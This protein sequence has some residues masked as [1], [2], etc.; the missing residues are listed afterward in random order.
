MKVKRLKIKRLPGI[1]QPFE[2]KM[3]GAGI[4]IIFGPNG[5]GKSSICR[6]VK[7]LY[8][9]N[10][11]PSQRISVKGDFELDGEHWLGRREGTSL[12]WR[13]EG[14]VSAA[15]NLP[16]FH[17]QQCFFL[18]LLDLI[19]PSLDSTTDIATEIKRQMWGGFDLDQTASK[20]FSDVT[21]YSCR[22]ERTN[23][24]RASMNVEEAKIQ[25]LHLQH[26][27]DKLES[28]E[29]K[30]K[31]A[32][33]SARRLISVERALGLADRQE[34]QAELMR[35]IKAL[36]NSL[37]RLI[38]SEVE[39]VQK[40]QSSVDKLTERIRSLRKNLD[41][42]RIQIQNS[43]LSAPLDAAEFATW[44]NKTDDLSQ[45][46]EKLNAAKT[47]RSARQ[48]ELS[49]ALS[50]IGE[51]KPDEIELDLTDHEQLF[52]FLRL[53]GKH[54]NKVSSIK[55]RLR[56]LERVDEQQDHEIDFDQYSEA[57][58][59]LRSWLREPNPDTLTDKN[60]TRRYWLVS[61]FILAVL[62]LLLAILVDP[63]FSL[64]AAVGIGIYLPVAF[65]GRIKP[66]SN[67]RET[68]ESAFKNM[69]VPEPDSW[70]TPS[71]ELRLHSLENE[72]ANHQAALQ[73]ARDRDVE[74]QTL[75]NKL[76]G[77][78]QEETDLEK[79]RQ[80][81][82]N[83]LG[84][85]V[86]LL[87]AEL[88]DAARALNQYRKAR[89]NF[90]LSVG[91]VGHLEIQYSDLLK[92]LANILTQYGE[93]PP[94]DAATARAHL[95]QLEFQIK[96]I[97]GALNKEQQ[98]TD[99]VE[100]YLSERNKE[101]SSIKNIY[102]KLAVEESDLQALQTLVNL[103]PDYQKLKNDAVLLEGKIELDRSE[104]N[105]VGESELA[106][107][108]ISSLELLKK[109][110][111]QA[112]DEE[113]ELRNEITEIKVQVDEAKHSQ[114]VQNLI[115]QREQ[116]RTKLHDLREKALFAKAGQFL[117]DDVR[118]RYEQTQMP[119]VYDRAR[120]HFSLFTKHS[121]ELHLSK[122]VN[123]HRLFATDLRRGSSLGRELS[124][125]SDGT[126]SQLLLAARIAFAEEVENG[127]ILPLFLDEALDQSDPVRFEAIIRSLGRIAKE[128][129]RQIFYLTCDNLDVDR[130]K[131]ALK[132]EG[133][134][135]AKAMDLGWVRQSAASIGGSVQIDVDPRP[136][137]PKPNGMSAAEYG[138]ILGVPVFRPLLGSAE[139][140]F[141]YLLSDDLA[142]LHDFLD[143]GIDSAGQWKTVSGT[144]LADKL[145]SRSISESD[146]ES[147][148]DL[149]RVFCQLWK[150][151]RG[152]PVDRDV[153][154]M[155]GIVS[156]RYLNDVVA[157]AD[158][159]AGDSEKLINELKAKTD[160]RLR[161]F[162]QSKCEELEQYLYDNGYLDERPVLDESELRLRALTSPAA[163]Q[164]PKG[165]ASELLHR[166]WN[167]A[168]NAAESESQK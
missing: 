69:N 134:K 89:Q 26:R 147:R 81:L 49:A 3:V 167:W 93:L 165:D 20:L 121:Y 153:I 90:N 38:G 84:L 61:A 149:L 4:Y 116:V 58:R 77:M 78:C 126:R 7:A 44:R 88:V 154:E 27:L 46:E 151:G 62:G 87:D 33:T 63:T 114:N 18:Q 137:V 96:K 86:T 13:Q 95:N 54:D 159:L 160:Q 35:K 94:T 47:E 14:E 12:R 138:K 8:W 124:E 30:L 118:T 105:K 136:K 102:Q 21:Q 110:L 113:T 100:Q 43:Q 66:S 122:E 70:E 146:I 80:A 22:K 40:F 28:L 161:G 76:N 140:H 155:S 128:Q 108:D 32:Q 25:Q 104:L 127:K 92:E 130:I 10:Y 91:E 125:L 9:E 41:A 107:L 85:D 64:L 83:R 103:L 98:L 56:L 163:N 67:S 144:L 19:D 162:W 55:E 117:I 141:F 109:E 119:R 115:T 129:N 68:Y 15:P 152:L 36:P 57:V 79:K 65:L 97:V 123:Q 29:T 111:L 17:N 99:Q 51:S 53:R 133:C 6:A 150:E 157:I 45:I 132:K 166:W 82:N 52:N 101:L 164:L 71:V 112:A 2:I 135:I 120:N 59:L 34:K 50:S 143:N 1:S 139:Q 106:T 73:R 75:K 23:F 142:L 16:P 168:V 31:S 72:T 39:Q 42:T 74:R 24:N 11:G 37:A 131:I 148:L 48:K 145:G 5:I 158:E 60:R 156:E